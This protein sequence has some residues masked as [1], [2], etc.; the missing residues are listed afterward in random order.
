MVHITYIIQTSNDVP[1]Q[2]LLEHIIGLRLKHE[3]RQA[4]RILPVRNSEQKTVITLD[5]VPDLQI[6]GRRQQ[7]SI[8]VIRSISQKVIIRI[9]ILAGIQESNLVYIA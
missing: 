4:I 6:A 3:R 8:V 1:P 7:S 2:I 5:K 9:Y